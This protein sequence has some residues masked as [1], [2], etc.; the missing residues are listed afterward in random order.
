M[1]EWMGFPLLV[2]ATALLCLLPL[3]PALLELRRRT[4]VAPLAIVREHDGNVRYFARQFREEISSLALGRPV[5]ETGPVVEGRLPGGAP[6][7]W[8]RGKCGVRNS[9]FGVSDGPDHSELR[10]PHSALSGD[11]MLISDGPLELPAG[12]VWAREMYAG[13]GLRGGA[14]SRYTGVLAE[15]PVRLG[16]GS[17]VARWIHSEASLHLERDGQITF[18][19]LVF[20]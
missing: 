14:G 12:T 10:I 17:V 15:G 13:A 3:L 7:R 5:A 2:A 16:A 6:F 20:R 18:T 9:E 11:R 19:D 1:M 8:V 4:D